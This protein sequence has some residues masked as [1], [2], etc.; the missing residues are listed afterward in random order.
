MNTPLDAVPQLRGPRPPEAP[1]VKR[2][3]PGPAPSMARRT[4]LGG[5]LATGTALGFTV[6]GVFPPARRAY[7]GAY[8]IYTGPCPSYTVDA[9]CSPGCGPS[10]VFPNACELSGPHRGYHRDDGPTWA[11]QPN[12]CMPG[13]FDGWLW[14]YGGA[15]GSCACFVEFRCHDGLRRTDSGW[16]K[17]ICKWTTKCGCPPDPEPEPD[18]P[19]DPLADSWPTD[20]PADPPPTSSEPPRLPSP[21]P[22][23]DGGGGGGLFDPLLRGLT[24]L[25]PG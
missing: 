8:E 3:L 12:N 13:G 4:V 20:P 24:R 1:T 19:A 10:M 5:L 14:Y 11:L 21:E 2:T 25:F 6:L 23:S 17:S 22:D 15:C 16:V 18:P 7:A 9:D